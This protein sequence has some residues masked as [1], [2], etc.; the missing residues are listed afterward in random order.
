VDTLYIGG[1]TPSRMTPEQVERLL[2][3]VRGRFALLPGAEVTLEANPEGLTGKRLA[4]YLEA[5]ITRISVGVQSLDDQVL[6][7]CGRAH[8]AARVIE[9]VARARATGFESVNV[10]LI[11]G[12][13]GEKLDRWEDTARRAAGLGADHVSVYLLESDKDTPLARRLR[14][15]RLRAAD[16]DALVE[17]Y[18]RAVVALHEAG[19]AQYEVSNFALAGHQSRHNLK[20]WSDQ[21]YG[22]FGLGAHAYLGGARRANR[23]DLD[24]YLADLAAGRDPRAWED[25]WEPRRR[26][27]EAVVLGLRRTA[28]IDLASLGERYEVDLRGLYARAWERA[29]DAGLIVWENT[30]VALTAAGRLRCNELFCELI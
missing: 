16:D 22:G 9:A 13:P 18:R 11:A 2:R 25:P 1:G 14:D 10:D 30:R 5:G 28:G 29:W 20:Y 27:G 7:A 26:L 17:A 23:R 24:G 12:L 15:G 21:P 4:G 6:A 19:L 3:V 8:D